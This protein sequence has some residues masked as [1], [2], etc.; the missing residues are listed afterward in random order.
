MKQRI[1]P[2]L[3]GLM[4]ITAVTVVVLGAFTRL[5]DAGLGC[6]DWPTC[7]GH[8]WIPDTQEEIQQA[9]QHLDLENN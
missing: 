5:V 3:S 1:L 2:T 4:L 9:N 8:L 6:P 7:Y